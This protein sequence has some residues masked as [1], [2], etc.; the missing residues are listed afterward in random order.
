MTGI[1]KEELYRRLAQARRMSNGAID[2][3][4]A[5]RLRSLVA[6]LESQLAAAETDDTDAP[7]GGTATA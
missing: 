7:P 3:I 6:E 4:T 1:D 2:S 5:E